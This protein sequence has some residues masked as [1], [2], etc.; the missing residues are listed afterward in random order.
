MKNGNEQRHRLASAKTKISMA[1]G[2]IAA[3]GMAKRK[4]NQSEKAKIEMKE[5]AAKEKAAVSVAAAAT[6]A[7]AK[8]WHIRRKSTATAECISSGISG[9]I[10][11]Q[12]A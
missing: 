9:E 7:E 3:K 6:S 8:R 5:I 11:R 12:L 2:E 4:R 1:S 10:K